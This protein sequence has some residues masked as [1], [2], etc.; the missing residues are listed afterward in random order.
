MTADIECT[1]YVAWN[2]AALYAAE[3]STHIA[4]LSESEKQS[5]ISSM[6]GY[7]VQDLDWDTLMNCLPRKIRE[8]CPETFIAIMV[9]KDLYERCME[10]SFW[11]LEP[12]PTVDSE[13]DYPTSFGEDLNNFCTRH[14]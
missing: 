1:A 10:N 7:C 12:D 3:D 4:G 5:I 14:S 2:W 8:F 13:T 11:Y 6:K 9:T